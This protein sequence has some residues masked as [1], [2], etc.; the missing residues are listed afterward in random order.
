MSNSP[1]TKQINTFILD[2]L[3][4]ANYESDLVTIRQNRSIGPHHTF[5][6]NE[7]RLVI[8]LFP[9]AVPC[10]GQLIGIYADEGKAQMVN[11]AEALTKAL[12]DKAKRYGLPD[13]PFILAIN[14]LSPWATYEED[15][16]ISLFGSDSIMFDAT[17][18]VY[19]SASNSVGFFINKHGQTHSRVSGVLF[20]K[21]YHSSVAG[22]T[23][24]LYHNPN[25]ALPIEPSSLNLSQKYIKDGKLQSIEVI[26]TASLFNKQE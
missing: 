13:K 21:A 11:P 19:L 12:N 26:P 2:V 6:N 23:L 7:V 10:P 25:A 3:E 4:K 5:E 17:N 14:A 8:S 9:K 20:A 24:V 15:F 22:S 16:T 1:S 18:R